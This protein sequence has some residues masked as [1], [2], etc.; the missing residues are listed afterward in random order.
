M[1]KPPRWLTRSSRPGRAGTGRRLVGLYP[2][3]DTYTNQLRA[4]EAYVRT[5]PSSSSGQF[6]LAYHYLVQGN[7]DAAG[8]R[9]SKRVVSFSPTTSSRRRSSSSTRRRRR[10]HAGRPAWRPRATAAAQAQCRAAL[11]GS[12]STGRGR[13][14]PARLPRLPRRHS[15]RRNDQPE[16]PEPPP[17]PPASLVGVWKAQASPDVAI[18]LTLQEDGQ[19]AW[20]VDTKGQEADTQRPAPAS[21]TTPW[22]C[23]SRMARPW[24]AR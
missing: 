7:N 9:C 12:R 21:R 15:H 1:T 22:P 13:R 6:L 8:D 18:A 14:Q 4:L 5:N 20:E 23:S 11:E 17:P 10:S 24:S 2:D 19:F 16:Q 3:V